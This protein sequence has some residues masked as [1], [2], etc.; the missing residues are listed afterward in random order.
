MQLPP[1]RHR[2]LALSGILAALWLALVTA[3]TVVGQ[4]LD[5]ASGWLRQFDASRNGATQ[6]PASHAGDWYTSH[7]TAMDVGGGA[8]CASCHSETWCTDCHGGGSAAATIHPAGFA[9]MHAFEALGSTAACSSCHVQE[10]FCSSC[11]LQTRWSPEAGLRPSTGVV[12]HP[13]G[14]VESEHAN[15]AQRDLT[16][17]ASCHSDESCASCH[18][19]VNPHG[20]GMLSDC[21]RMLDAAAPTCVTCHTSSSRMPMEA[22]QQDPRCRR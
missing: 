3:A 16:Q 15:A 18:T 8:S 11:H 17:C 13:P 20:P 19:F 7:G 22:V 21:A 2:G 12:V 6:A 9:A 1:G 5:D 4:S 14:W 10:L